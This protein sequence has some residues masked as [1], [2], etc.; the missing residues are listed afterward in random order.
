MTLQEVLSRFDGV[1]ASTNG[2]Y[3]A[4][5]P[6]HD[7]KRASLSIGTKEN[8]D[9]TVK[10]QAGCDKITVLSRVGLNLDD[11]KQDEICHAEKPRI[12]AIYDYKSDLGKGPL[13]AQKLRK[14]DKSFS[15]RQPDGKGGW[16]WNRKGV[17]H[18]LYS[19]GEPDSTVYI[20]EGEKDADN[21]AKL[22]CFCVSGADG[23]GHDKWHKEYTAQLQGRSVLILPDNDQVGREYAEE[24]AQAL[25]GVTK[26][27]K[28]FDLSTAWAEIPE[29]GD[30]SDMI[31]ALGQD[32]TAELL[33]QLE[34]ETAEWMPTATPEPKEQV[35]PRVAKAAAE[36]GEDDTSFLWYPY[37]PIGDYTVMMAD[38]G[39]GKTLLCC[40]IIGNVSSGRRL[41]G[42]AFDGKGRNSLIISGEDSGEIL[43]KRLKSS[44]A[45]LE[46]VFILD[47]IG[48]EGMSISEKYEEFEASVLE[49]KPVLVVLDPWHAFLGEKV[50]ISRVNA[51]RPILQK[52]SNLCKRGNCAMILISH[53]NKRAQGENA[54][55]AATGSTDLINAARSAFRVIF[56]ESDDNSRIMVHT[57]SNYA[58]Y[59]KSIRY[60]IED[61]GVEWN[62][63]SEITRTTLEQA[64]RRRS[65]PGEVMND[66][67]R[68]ETTSSALI[69]ALKKATNPFVPTRYT[70]EKFK[71]EYGE[72]IFGGRQ[73]KKALDNVRDKLADEGYFLRTGI[74]VREGKEKKGNGF[75]IQQIND[76]EHEQVEIMDG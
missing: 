74:Q 34:I 37:L 44:G 55:N 30:I 71:A 4:K 17:P 59:G 69:V 51:L 9:L 15:W 8:G 73:P 20:V 76:V 19:T 13:L 41:P 54:N 66:G 23:A 28:V 6:C 22:G 3:M 67:E 75:M 43:K 11:L 36:F 60:R 50:D 7:D 52:L 33:A 2:W 31:A 65:T 35:K 56:D 16:I 48:S 42:E 62:G 46:K 57:K 5:C 32:K 58:P 72:L 12:V 45:D 25:Y 29:K 24:V 47:R 64:A 70:Y 40:G 21:L 39:T 14:S 68:K 38:G 63:Y 49:Y 53:V 18:A 61:G 27:C 10:C 26:S 1:K